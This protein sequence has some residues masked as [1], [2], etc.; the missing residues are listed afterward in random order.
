METTIVHWGYLGI[1]EKKM[2]TAIAVLLNQSQGSRYLNCSWPQKVPSQSLDFAFRF[3][4]VPATEVQP[5]AAQTPEQPEEPLPEELPR[6]QPPPEEPLQEEP[7][8]EM[9]KWPDVQVQVETLQEASIEAEAEPAA[10]AFE[11][12]ELPAGTAAPEPSASS[13]A[14]PEPIPTP[15]P[16]LEEVS[17]AGGPGAAPPP[18]QVAAETTETDEVA[19]GASQARELPLLPS[20][21]AE[22]GEKALAPHWTQRGGNPCIQ[23]LE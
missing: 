12:P 13:E 19:E 11:E 2:E 21:E 9:P 3:G 7:P 5:A 1:M 22:A 15:Q 16:K 8:A 18:P 4:Q 14:A 23:G 10:Q 17:D 20:D 6:E